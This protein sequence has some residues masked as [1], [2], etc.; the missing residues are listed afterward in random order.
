MSKLGEVGVGIVGSGFIAEA[1]A[2]S[3][4][5]SV[6]AS[7]RVVASKSEEHAAAFAGRWECPSSFGLP[8]GTRTG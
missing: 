7:L 1:H 6:S 3:L 2:Q 4:S 5:Q 8:T